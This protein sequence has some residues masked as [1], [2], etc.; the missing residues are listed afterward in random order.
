M[1]IYEVNVEVIVNDGFPHNRSMNFKERVDAVEV[2]NSVYYELIRGKEIEINSPDFNNNERG[3]HFFRFKEGPRVE[4]K[5]T[6]YTVEDDTKS[7]YYFIGMVESL[8][9]FGR[10]C[11]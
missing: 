4:I 7:K 1:D 2:A 11:L 6:K 5:V 3:Y 8:L 10:E 9:E